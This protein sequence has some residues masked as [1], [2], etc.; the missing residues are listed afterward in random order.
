[1]FLAF[2][3]NQFP[4]TTSR[5]AHPL[6]KGPSCTLDPSLPVEPSRN[7]SATDRKYLAKIKAKFLN[8]R[9]AAEAARSGDFNPPEDDLVPVVPD[10]L[11]EM[12][13]LIYDRGPENIGQAKLFGGWLDESVAGRKAG[14]SPQQEQAEI[15]FSKAMNLFGRGMYKQATALFA[16]ATQLVG[17]E[18]RLG[19][20]YQLWQAQALDAAGD[21][22]KATELFGSLSIHRDGEVRKVSRELLFIITAPK[23]QLD[24]NSFVQIPDIDDA[25]SPLT[26]TLLNMS[27]FNTLRTA[28]VEKAPERHSLQWYL[29]REKPQEVEDHSAVQAV[30]VAAAI[31][32]TLAFMAVSPM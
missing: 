4:L 6:V 18:T 12:D 30:A 20:Q 22:Q 1:M 15:V 11:D 25:K 2:T 9:R 32:G 8:A 29:D 10:D 21:K 7:L 16:Q 28:P 26:S 19:G 14:T 23:L 31:V 27:N 3:S 24:R 13:D 5:P 17:S